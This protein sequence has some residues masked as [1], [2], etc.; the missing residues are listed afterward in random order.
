MPIWYLP[1]L[2]AIRYSTLKLLH[3]TALTALSS[4]LGL[5]HLHE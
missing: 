2:N 1:V 4:V 5:D 3:N